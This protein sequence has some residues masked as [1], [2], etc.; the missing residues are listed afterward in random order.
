VTE[1]EE[2]LFEL[3]KN[4]GHPTDKPKKFKEFKKPEVVK[5]ASKKAQS[6]KKAAKTEVKSKSTE[7]VK[8]NLKAEKSESKAEATKPSQ[9]LVSTEKG[10][11]I[12][13]SIAQTSKSVLNNTAN[14]T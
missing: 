9:K 13:A 1:K 5:T 2:K 11:K 4:I 7:A 12:G 6:D 14:S 8:T 10:P 3:Q